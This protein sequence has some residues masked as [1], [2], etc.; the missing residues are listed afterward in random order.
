MPSAQSPK[1]EYTLLPRKQALSGRSRM[2]G[3]TIREHGGML[4]GQSLQR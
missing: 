1:F 3:K 4:V 2:S